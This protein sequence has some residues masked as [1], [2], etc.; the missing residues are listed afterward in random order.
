[1]SPGRKTVVAGV[2]FLVFWGALATYT[3]LLPVKARASLSY[4]PVFFPALLIGLGIV[5]SL[6]IIGQG[7][8]ANRRAA[9]AAMPTAEAPHNVRRF[10]ALVVVIGIY[11]A[12]MPVFGFLVTSALFIPAFTLTLGYRNWMVIVALAVLGPVAI[13]LVFTYGLK[14]PLPTFLGG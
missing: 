6:I 7:V 9:A 3:A 2:A 8:L 12:A 14:A 10:L 5:L 1:M 13:W 4:N 11:F